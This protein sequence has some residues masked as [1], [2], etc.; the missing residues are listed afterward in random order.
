MGELFGDPVVATAILDRLLHHSH[1]ITDPRGQ[2]PAARKTPRR[3]SAKGAP[4]ASETTALTKGGLVF[5][6]VTGL[7]SDVV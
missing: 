6:V 4:A 7:V 2:L 1:I 5:G 3:A